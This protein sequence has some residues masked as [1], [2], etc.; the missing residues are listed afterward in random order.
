[1]W[2]QY[3]ENSAKKLGAIHEF[4][5][6]FV[7]VIYKFPLVYHRQM[8]VFNNY[9]AVNNSAIDIALIAD[10]G[11]ER[12]G[13]RHGGGKFQLIQIYH[14]QVASHTHSKLAPKRWGF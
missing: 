11:K 12:F 5:P 3:L 9:P 1:M 4:L 14:K 7:C 6:A 8:P 10:R 2:L 13:I